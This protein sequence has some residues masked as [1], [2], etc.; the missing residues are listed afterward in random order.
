MANTV[1]L[2]RSA[3]ASK[4]P[5]TAD[6]QL[7]EL[8]INTFDGKLFLKKDNGTASIVEI[9]A[10]GSGSGDVV[11]PTS[12]TDNAVTRFDGTTGKLIQNS[13]V[14]IDDSGNMTFT[15]TGARIRG[16]F[17]NATVA[18]RLLFQTSTVNGSTNIIT[19]PNGTGP[20]SSIGSRNSQDP[21]N[22]S[23]INIQA[24]ASDVRINS[25]ITGTGTYQP[26]VF[27][28]GGSERVRIDTSGNVGIGTNSP[29][30]YG[31]FA[32]VGSG[33]IGVFSNATNSD[34]RINIGTSISSITNTQNAPITIGTN[35]AER[36]R[37]SAA[38]G[39]SIGTSTD[40]GAKNLLVDGKVTSN[41]G[42]VSNAGIIEVSQTI[43]SSYTIASGNSAISAGNVTVAAGAI[44]TV[45]AGSVWVI[46]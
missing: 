27:Y 35:N 3:V 25:G 40:A 43:T 28:T 44:V 18:N 6:L 36:M 46:L 9:G 34:L 17:S 1:R 15:A 12:A 14:T 30:A 24:N 32:V 5:T 13:S 45:P 23:W 33:D 19:I 29:S 39:V 16:D 7:G 31:K 38:G 22:S 21:D 20:S 4:V 37:L 11:G 2:K 41:T 42:M 10:G 8:A 26:M